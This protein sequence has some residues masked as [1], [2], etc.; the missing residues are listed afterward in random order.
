MDP[1]FRGFYHRDGRF[2]GLLAW[3]ARDWI[4]ERRKSGD[5]NTPVVEIRERNPLRTV[6]VAKEW[7]YLAEGGRKQFKG[8]EVFVE[9]FGDVWP[10]TEPRWWEGWKSVPLCPDGGDTDSTPL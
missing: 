9:A 4:C 5:N 10:Q 3:F 8:E 6:E 1:Y 2:K 7:Q